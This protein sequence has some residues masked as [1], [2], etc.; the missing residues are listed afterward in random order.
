MAKSAAKA[1]VQIVL[2]GLI[3]LAAL[4]MV[5]TNLRNLATVHVYWKSVTDVSVAWLMVLSG[6]GG[7]VVAVG[8]WQLTAGIRTLLARRRKRAKQAQADTSSD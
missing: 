6:L 1:F 2:A 8:A 7:I 5:L 4:V 3:L